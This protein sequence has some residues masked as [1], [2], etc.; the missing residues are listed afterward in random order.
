MGVYSKIRQFIFFDLVN[1]AEKI[2]AT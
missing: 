2:T 1:L